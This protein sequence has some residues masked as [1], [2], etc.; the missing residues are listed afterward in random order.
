MTNP[1]F[2]PWH[3][4]HSAHGGFQL[5]VADRAEQG[6]VHFQNLILMSLF[7]VEVR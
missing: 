3:Y 2:R 7:G 4:L 5:F 1:Y 6:V